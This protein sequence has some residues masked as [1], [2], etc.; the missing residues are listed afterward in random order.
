[1]QIKK[2]PTLGYGGQ[3]A[4][5][6]PANGVPHP[7]LLGQ[8]RSVELRVAAAQIEAVGLWRGLIMQ[9]AK[10]HQLR[11]SGFQ[12]VEIVC[13]VKTKGFVPRHG[14]GT[15]L[16]PL[17]ALGLWRVRHFVGEGQERVQ[18]HGFLKL[19]R[20]LGEAPGQVLDLPRRLQP[21]VSALDVSRLQGRQI[22][23]HRQ[24]RLL[25][26]DRFQVGVERRLA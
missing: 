2:S 26:Q 12:G 1:M 14:N 25:L 7:R 8:L 24:A 4:G 16:L 10:K 22:A 18:I 19:H 23:Q 17:P 6:R 5:H 13:V 11:P 9:G 15:G 21:Q 20:H 3:A